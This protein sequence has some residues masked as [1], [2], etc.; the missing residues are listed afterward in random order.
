MRKAAEIKEHDDRRDEA[1]PQGDEGNQRVHERSES[2]VTRRCVVLRPAAG[3]FAEYNRVQ[4]SETMLDIAATGLMLNRLHPHET[5]QT[6][7]NV[8]QTDGLEVV[9]SSARG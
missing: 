8:V 9:S 3:D 4:T 1:V 2:H 7:S 6:S 5:F